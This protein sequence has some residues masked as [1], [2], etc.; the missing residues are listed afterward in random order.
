MKVSG[1]KMLQDKGW[2]ADSEFVSDSG[3][4]MSIPANHKL[5]ALDDNGDVVN[6][7]VQTPSPLNLPKSGSPLPDFEPTGSFSRNSFGWSIKVRLY[8]VVK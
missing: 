6:V 5:V 4:R 2:K 7:V 1:L 8:P 3:Q